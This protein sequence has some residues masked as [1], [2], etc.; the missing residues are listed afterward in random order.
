M[1]CGLLTGAVFIDLR[2]AFDTVHHQQ[3][4]QKLSKYRIIDGSLKWFQVYLLDRKQMVIFQ[5]QPSTSQIVNT[6]VPQGSVLGPLLF[7]IYVNDLTTMLNKCEILLY[8][9]DTVI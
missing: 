4:V 6:G 1:D 3:L 9:D 2:K 8:A 7:L 5:G